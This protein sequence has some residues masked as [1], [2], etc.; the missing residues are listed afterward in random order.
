MNVGLITNLQ[1]DHFFKQ[2][3]L[4]ADFIIEQGAIPLIE[5]NFK[6]LIKNTLVNFVPLNYL[7]E[8]SDFIIILGGD[9]TILKSAKQIAPFN[10]NI[11]GINM[12]NL[13]YLADVELKDCF[14]AISKVLNNDFNVEKRMMLNCT[15]NGQSLL[16]LNELNI[17]NGNSSRMINIHL[18]INNKPI[19]SV[20][21]DGIIV[22]TP[23][24]STAY[25]LSAGGPILKPD[26]E[27][28]II[29]YVCPHT[30]F[31]RPYVISSSDKV[32]LFVSNSN[33]TP[34]ISIDGEYSFK[35]PE[36]QKVFIEKSSLYTN[37]IKT[38][39]LCFYDILKSKMVDLRGD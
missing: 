36:Y 27:L 14:L 9:G 23:T 16:S 10:K 4:I 38:T 17:N 20:R 5:S 12:G 35:L 6:N 31:S 19:N 26:T 28:I 33:S 8:N 25:N 11:L 21:A 22:S 13:G 7:I 30:L 32:T 37:I 3:N 34:F 18:E 15:F 29:T 24:G 39:N 2:T 1:K